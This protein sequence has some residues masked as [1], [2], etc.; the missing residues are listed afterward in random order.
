MNELISNRRN[1]AAWVIVAG[2]MVA[3]VVLS[4]L[5]KKAKQAA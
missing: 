3:M 4:L 5:D 2:I 1:V